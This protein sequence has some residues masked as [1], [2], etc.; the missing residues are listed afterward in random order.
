MSVAALYDIHGNLPALEAVLRDVPEDATVVIGGDIAAG[1]MPVETLELLQALGD[2]AAWIRGNADRDGGVES[3]LW[4]RRTDWMWEKVGAES[5][6]FLDG[7]P[8]TVSL[9]VDGLGETLFCHGS[10]R[11]DEEAITA[12]S[13]EE[14][15]RAILAGAGTAV[16]VCG[17]THHQF[18][19][20]VDGVRV[21][22]AGSVGMPYEGQRGAYWTLLGPD[23]EHRH[24]EYDVDTAVEAIRASG[25]PDPG[26]LIEILTEPPSA[27]EAAEEL[28]ERALEKEAS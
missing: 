4:R 26:E 25:Y 19:R 1:P 15:L 23:V 16:V 22:N 6:R 8:Q 28:E 14:R 9:H 2:R 21:V 7:L 11:S 27:R 17:H 12:V 10:P 24:T 20:R 5:R 3:E 13:G 18:D